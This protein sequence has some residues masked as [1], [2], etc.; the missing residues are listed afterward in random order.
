M[1]NM[2]V[3]IQDQNGRVGYQPI[4]QALV[5][6]DREHPCPHLL[7]THHSYHSSLIERT[8]HTS[9]TPIQDVRIDHCRGHF[10]VA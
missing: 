4:G 3:V 10:L 6:A 7:I 5:E 8:A 9:P 2:Y 1:S